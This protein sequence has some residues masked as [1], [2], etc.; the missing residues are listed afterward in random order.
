MKYPTSNAFLSLV[1]LGLSIPAALNAAGGSALD[2]ILI[3]SADVSS[4]YDAGNGRYSLNGS[5]YYANSG[6]IDFGT[7]NFILGKDTTDN[8]L[9]ISSGTV[10]NGR[11]YIGNDAGSSGTM[12]VDGAGATLTN[13]VFIIVGYDGTGAL[14]VKNDG[15]VTSDITVNVGNDAGSNGTVTVTGAGSTL[16]SGGNC[17]VGVAGTGT[18]NIEKGGSLSCS[19]GTIGS[20]SGSHGSMT[21]AGIDSTWTTTGNLF[22][23]DQGTGV[24]TISGGAKVTNVSAESYYGYAFI[25]YQGGGSGTAT[26]TGAGSS[27]ANSGGLYVGF[28]GTGS[29]TISNGGSVS[30]ADG[31]IGYDAFGTGAGTVTVDGIGST[32]LNTGELK[33]G[34]GGSGTLAILNGGLVTCASLTVSE[35]TSTILLGGGYLVISGDALVSVQDILNGGTTVYAW[36]AVTGQ[37]ELVTS[38]TSS[39]VS[40]NYY[41]SASENSA[42]YAKLGL[43][44]GSYTVLTS[45]YSVPE[46]STYALFG[47]LGALALVLVRR[48]RA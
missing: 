8:T 13:S 12:T 40:L 33:I 7:G 16:T 39:L 46:P 1:A 3:T 22:I 28:G 42:L 38:S 15:T 21:L 36:N 2:P 24:L 44:D 37:F 26:V 45:T 30:N 41:A 48:R 18:V 34:N 29:L 43:A 23:G 5:E 47:G 35:T 6:D 11:C 20:M 25:G 27:W 31:L 32:W 14:N 10:S 4:Y 9:T 19:D 17:I